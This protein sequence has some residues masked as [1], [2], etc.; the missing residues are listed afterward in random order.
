MVSSGAFHLPSLF[1]C[2]FVLRWFGL[3]LETLCFET[4]LF[5]GVALATCSGLAGLPFQELIY[6]S[7]FS[8]L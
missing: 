7:P 3:V 5:V 6:L 1:V 4:G 8:A 2:L